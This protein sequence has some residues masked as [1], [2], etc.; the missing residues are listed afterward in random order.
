MIET[1]QSVTINAAIETVWDYVSNIERWASLMPGLQECGIIDAHN[2]RWTLKVGAGGM[3]RTVKVLVH[4]EAWDG[5]EQVRFSYRLEGDPV[6]GGGTYTATRK[7]A[8][9]TDI[10]LAVRVCGQ[11]PMAPMWEALGKPLLPRFVKA[12]AGQ[13]KEC[14]EQNVAPGTAPEAAKPFH[15]L[16]FIAR[17]WHR[18]FGTPRRA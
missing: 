17:L 1:E 6:D 3:V 9:E 7:S 2:S 18:L 5:P 12:F 16:D 15:F 10:T 4:I 13:L 11:G 14:I 8:G